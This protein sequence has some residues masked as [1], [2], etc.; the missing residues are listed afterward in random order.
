VEY[1]MAKINLNTVEA[2]QALSEQGLLKVGTGI[3]E[4]KTVSRKVGKTGAAYLEMRLQGIA[5][6]NERRN[7]FL[8]L[9]HGSPKAA[10]LCLEIAHKMGAVMEFDD[11]IQ[12]ELDSAFMGRTLQCTVGVRNRAQ[13]ES[14]RP[15]EVEN[16]FRWE[17]NGGT[18]AISEEESFSDD[19]SP[20]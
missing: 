3:F 19:H 15:G 20:F 10:G 7:T 2:K 18:A 12:S 6:V 4:V 8:R 17:A 11:E 9:P 14:Y 5:G 13:T 1:V 16:T